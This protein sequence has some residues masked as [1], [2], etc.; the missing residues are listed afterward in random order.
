MLVSCENILIRVVMPRETAKD[1]YLGFV[2]SDLEELLSST[3]MKYKS[4][5][6][7]F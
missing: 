6:N 4:Y 2:G 1:G 5:L 3:A 7:D